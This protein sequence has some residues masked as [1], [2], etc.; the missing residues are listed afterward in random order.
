LQKNQFKN[1]YVHT[2]GDNRFF[3]YRTG[4]TVYEEAFSNHR[5][6]AA[7]WN[8]SGFPL[9]IL[10]DFPSHLDWNAFTEPQAFDLEADGV[11]LS[12]EWDYAGFEAADETLENG[13]AVTHGTVTLKSPIKPLTV[14]V[15][16]ILDGTAVFTR[17]L[18]VINEGDAPINLNLVNPMCGGVEI[19]SDWP[20]YMMGAP[21]PEK[22]YSLG[23]MDHAQWGHEGYFKWHDL[24]NA[25]YSIA[26]RYQGS[27]RYRHPMFML[28]NN[29]LGQMMICQLGWAGG[30]R[31]DFTL[32]TDVFSQAALSYRIVM[33]SQKPIAR[34][35]PE[36]SFETPH[37]HMGMLQ[38]DLDDAVNAM[39]DHLRKSVFTLPDARGVKGWIEGGM[40]PE[41]LMSVDYTKHFA[42]TMAEV[43]AETMIIDAGWYCPPG[44]ASHEWHPRAGDW[45]PDPDLYPNGIEEIRDYIHEKGL[46]FGLWLDLERIGKDSNI[47][48]EHPEWIS[49]CYVNGHENSQ[50]NMAIP[51]AVAWAESELTRVIR[52]Y[53]IDL[54]RLDYN[55]GD[56]VLLNNRINRGS[57]PENAF[58]RYYQNTNAMYNR[59]RK[60]FPNV[61]FENCAGGGGRTD[62]GFV[63]NFTHTWVSDWNRAP[64]SFA[65]LNGMTM[66][67]PPEMVDRLVSGMFCHTR[68]SLDFQVR[69]A[70]LG[71]PSTNDYHTID[72]VKNPE[73]FAIVK[74]AIDLYKQ[75]IRPHIEGSKI[76]HHTPDVVSGQ[77]GAT[78]VVE[79]PQGYGI[80]ERASGDQKHSVMGIFNL[81]DSGSD[82]VYTLYPKGISASL[83]Y[84]VMLDNSGAAFSMTGAALLNEGLKVRLPGPLTSELVILEA[85]G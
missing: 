39:H 42:D 43:G 81:A 45:Y 7:G 36:E 27:N 52:D 13:T 59:L 58:V 40:G 48:K 77:D 38:G 62:V 56:N 80:L 31:F 55:L 12:W 20:G 30:Y 53:K 19:I 63:S 49:Q 65:V 17:Y 9:N 18:E 33:D 54:F 61:V 85:E 22:I 28:R 15:H 26:S 16:T 34:L 83:S 44:K 25:T 2:E 78:S 74:H 10:D 70:I 69:V 75:Y 37:V 41:R 29:L 57:G 6:T 67:L 5:Y 84:R 35:E 64:R 50:L 11:S 51:E 73:Q 46:L 60:K 14:K 72:S 47:A 71:R 76:F 68:A 82:T 21:Q 23:Y 79:H 1:I 4:L 8:I 3:C 24:P 66:A 32:N